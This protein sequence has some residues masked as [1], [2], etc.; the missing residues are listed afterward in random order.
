MSAWD[1]NIGDTRDLVGKAVGHA[2]GQRLA[3]GRQYIIDG[4]GEKVYGV[5]FIPPDEPTPNVIVNAPAH[6]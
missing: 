5:W 2:L 4:N 3:S 1:L 6:C